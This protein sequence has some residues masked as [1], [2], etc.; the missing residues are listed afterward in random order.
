VRI[1]HLVHKCAIGVKEDA[2]CNAQPSQTNRKTKRKKER[3][4]ERCEVLR[5]SA[6]HYYAHAQTQAATTTAQCD[7]V[8]I[9][10]P[11]LLS[12]NLQKKFCRQQFRRGLQNNL[13]H[14]AGSC[15]DT[16]MQAGKLGHSRRNQQTH[17]IK[18]FQEHNK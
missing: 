3:K 9:S 4:K 6:R 18:G 11:N 13:A 1:N 15:L 7:C 5:A 2:V 17:R 8:C 12:A 14:A 16:T 10:S